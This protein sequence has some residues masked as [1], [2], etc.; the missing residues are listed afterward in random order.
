M[1]NQ[2]TKA[3]VKAGESSFAIVDDPQAKEVMLSAF[4]TLG[5]SNFQLS[6][7]RI[8]AGGMTA[9]EVES[10][11]GS[12]VEPHLDVILLAMKGNQKAWWAKPLE[13]AGGGAPPSCSSTDGR[14]GWGVNSMDETE[15]PGEHACAECAWNQ[16][17]SARGKGKGKDCSDFAYLFFF[18]QGARIPSM[19][20]VPATSLKGLQ[21]YVL[22][23]I[24]AGKRMEGCITRLGLKKAQSASG[25]TYATLDLSWQ[26]DLDEDASA[27]MVELANQFRSRLTDFQDYTSTQEA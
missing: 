2:K 21:S 26:G 23:L 25:I 8:P 4:D 7:L 10:L 13:E 15:E 20:M 9:W 18:Q 12:T 11:E 17:G 24:D 16:F 3:L 5:L 1:A 6:R 14:T 27:G 19:L 22:R